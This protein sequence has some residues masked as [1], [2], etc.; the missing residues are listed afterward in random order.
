MPATDQPASDRTYLSRAVEVTVHIGLLL[1][2]VAFTF[3]IAQPFIG[4]II[5]G[6]IIAVAAYP[7]VIRMAGAIGGR[8]GPAALVFTL[9]ALTLLI[10]PTVK[11]GGAAAQNLQTL[12]QHLREGTL[13]VPAPRESVTAWPLVGEPIYEFWKLAESNLEEAVAKLKPQVVALAKWLLGMSV[14]TGLGILQ[15]IFSVI[16]AGIFL[17]HAR[18]ARESTVRVVERLAGE[19]RGER[20]VDLSRSTVQ[21]VVNGILGIAVIQAL[22][23]ALGFVVMGI[24]AAGV[25]AAI[26]LVLA[27]VQVGVFIVLLPLSIYVFSVTDPGVA[28]AFLAWNIF[29]GLI[30]NVLKPILLARGVAAPMVVVFVGAIGGL[31]SSGIIGLFVG[32][33]ILVLAY[34]LFRAW[35]EEGQ[36][37]EGSVEETVKQGAS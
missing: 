29:V 2:I 31:L 10:W 24:P 27:V 26:C 1:A 13:D 12:A 15:F 20:L 17:A 35:L 23:A 4:P 32:P 21:S 22:L 30:D 6:A 28:T 16:I 8:Q 5:W 14:G 7:L 18:G 34:T 36:T 37:G 33:V 9:L 3:Q 11:L 25:L 19:G